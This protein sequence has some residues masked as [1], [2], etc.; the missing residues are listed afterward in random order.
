VNSHA[1]RDFWKLFH[2]LPPDVRRE[3]RRAFDLF[4]KDAFDP[5]LQ[6]K[7]MRGH[8]GLW[9]AR[10]GRDYRALGRRVGAEIR[11]FWIGSRGEYGKLVDRLK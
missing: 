7:E 1:D 10:I 6:F 4:A 9:S 11:W 2:A 5:Q 8:P 3:A